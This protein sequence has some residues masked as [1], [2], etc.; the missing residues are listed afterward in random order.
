[1]G[2]FGD[3]MPLV[4]YL[5]KGRKKPVGWHRRDE[6]IAMAANPVPVKAQMEPWERRLVRA[7]V[8]P[9]C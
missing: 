6:R 4:A 9:T 3:V 2:R 7:R 8:P 5:R 1:M